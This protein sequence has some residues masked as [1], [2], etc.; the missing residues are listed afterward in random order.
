MEGNTARRYNLIAAYDDLTDARYAI[1]RL[2][3]GGLRGDAISLLGRAGQELAETD[4][5]KTEDRKSI[6]DAVIG[7]VTGAV[8]GGVLGG[9]AGF[10]IGL[11]TLPVPG[12]GPV[13]TAGVWGATALGAIGGSSAGSLVGVLSGTA[14][15]NE[16]DATYRT[17]LERG[18]VLVGVSTD[19]QAEFDRAFGLM[20]ET[21]PLSIDRYGAGLPAGTQGP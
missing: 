5:G 7:T 15:S 19:D 8:G 14:L 18:H 4:D 6:K 17:H 12:V 10:L 11:A 1:E 9:V 13:I 20:A 2:R 16:Q 21:Q 3:D